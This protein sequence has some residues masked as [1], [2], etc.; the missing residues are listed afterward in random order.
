MLCYIIFKHISFFLQFYQKQ[1]HAFRTLENTI[2]SSSSCICD[3][4]NSKCTESCTYVTKQLKPVGS[5][6]SSLAFLRFPA[7]IHPASSPFPK[8]QLLLA[9]VHSPDL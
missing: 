8:P 5:D 3:C 9:P 6:L 2:N 7:L 1:N 4:L